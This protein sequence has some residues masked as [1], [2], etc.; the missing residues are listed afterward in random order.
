MAVPAGIFTHESDQQIG[1]F[2]YGRKYLERKNALPV[3]PVALPLGLTPRAVTTNKGLYGAF[4]DGPRI[5]GDGWSS[6]PS[7][8]SPRKPFP[9]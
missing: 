4:R 7:E 5:T 2:A 1:T 9:K 3:D 8:R 6:R